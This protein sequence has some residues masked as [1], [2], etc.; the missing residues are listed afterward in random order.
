MQ[1]SKFKNLAKFRMD[2]ET[3]GFQHP[4][5]WEKAIN[6][7]AQ[8]WDEV[9]KELL[10]SIVESNTLPPM[11][12]YVDKGIRPWLSQNIKEKPLTDESLDSWFKRW[13]NGEEYFILMDKLT[14]WS[15]ILHNIVVDT[16]I[17]PMLEDSDGLRMGASCYAVFGN[18]GFTPFGIHKDN[19]PIVLINCGPGKKDVWFWEEKPDSSLIGSSELLKKSDDWEKGAIHYCIDVGDMVFI[20]R[21]VY[22]LLHTKDFSSMIGVAFFPGHVSYLLPSIIRSLRNE[23]DS[24]DPKVLWNGDYRPE[25]QVMKELKSFFSTESQDF[26]KAIQREIRRLHAKLTSNAFLIEPPQ[27]KRY[28]WNH[29]KDK[30]FR[31]PLHTQIVLVEEE[32]FLE[33]Y[34]RGRVFN[35]KKNEE[36]ISMIKHINNGKAFCL[37]DIINTVNGNKTLAEEFLKMVFDFQG[38]VLDDS[39]VNEGRN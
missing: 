23:R 32:E 20:P 10:S 25:Q 27:P 18:Y 33:M 4:R 31:L 12:I 21:G 2:Q 24:D 30:Y 13:L 6:L 29:C 37:Q 17:A 36:V 1:I 14:S 9:L 15:Y 16:F 28:T 22:H 7:D 35:M 39:Y 26:D 8:D 11:S 38:V 19:E 34:I 3:G 5:Y